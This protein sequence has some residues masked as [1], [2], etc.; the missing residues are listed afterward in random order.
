MPKSPRCSRN[1]SKLLILL[2]LGC[3]GRGGIAAPHAPKPAE[4]PQKVQEINLEQWVVTR[5]DADSL[6]KIHARGM[7]RLEAGS[8]S[9]ALQDFDLYVRVAPLGPLAPSA[10]FHA[11]LALDELG[12][13]A[14]ALA[15]FQLVTQRFPRG[16]FVEG[17]ALRATRLACHLERWEEARAA[18]DQLLET[19]SS[20][21]PVDIILV[22][23]A[24]ALDAVFR[25]DDVAAEM[26]VAK[27]RNAIE[28]NGLDAPGKIPRDIAAVYFAL[29][30]TKRL[31]A[32]RIVLASPGQDFSERLERRCE[33]L[34]A[35]QA[36]YSDA[37]RAFDAHWSTMAGYR[38]GELYASLHEELMHIT[39][40]DS[41][42]SV[43]QRQLFEGAMRL[44][45]S[46]LVQKALTMMKH[47]VDMAER[48]AE[49]SVWVNRAKTAEQ[50]L[51]RR[52]RE[53]QAALDRLPH[54]RQALEY[55]LHLV[56]QTAARK[57]K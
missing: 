36:A 1:L 54:S 19:S 15:R 14:A 48:S 43:S 35:G 27:A 10:H 40:P 13:F 39:P 49:R 9:D 17:A 25:G 47:T 56:E 23:G 28:N 42:L 11:A 33:L 44:R 22:E 53:E 18:A 57:G 32:E 37:M 6:T 30:E 21:R 7:E 8:F 2:N 26:H 4:T 46:I 29:G 12:R 51:E 55:A 24:L 5:R 31:R 38:I 41:N 45:Y 34:L 50:D 52:L 16:D 3:A 20:L